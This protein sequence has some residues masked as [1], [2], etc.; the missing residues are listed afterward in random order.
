MFSVA[1]CQLWIVIK[2]N[3]TTGST[4]RLKA[5]SYDGQA[6]SYFCAN[7]TI[8]SEISWRVFP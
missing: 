4:L 2:R 3:I 5:E 1:L 7:L 8:S 6:L